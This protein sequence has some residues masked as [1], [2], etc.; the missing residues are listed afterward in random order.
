MKPS[1]D[2]RKVLEQINALEKA[3]GFDTD[4]L[5]YAESVPEPKKYKNFGMDVDANGKINLK[6]E[7]DND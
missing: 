7:E 2:F 5:K 6:L 3:M 1:D 4:L